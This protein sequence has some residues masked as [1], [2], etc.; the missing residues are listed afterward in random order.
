LAPITAR[1]VAD[2]TAGRQTGIDL[3]PYAVTRF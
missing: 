2:M 1:I 3:A